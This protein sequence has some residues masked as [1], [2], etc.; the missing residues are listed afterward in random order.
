MSADIYEILALAMRYWFVLL[1]CLIVWRAFSWLRKDRRQTHKR[2]K[3]LPD[4]GMIGELVVLAGSDRLP[5]GSMIPVPYEGTLGA[6]R[7]CD[8][9]V[10]VHSVQAEHLDFSFVPGKGL[11]IFPRKGCACTVDGLAIVTRRDS[12]STPMGH[13]SVL[14]IGD[15][16]V[17]RLRL[18]AGLDAPMHV[19]HQPFNTAVSTS[20]A[21][22][23]PWEHPEEPEEVWSEASDRSS[24]YQTSTR[25]PRTRR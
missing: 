17:L 14:T 1:G 11:L 13:S 2:L 9:V 4:A 12:R 22:N 8:V 6:L 23:W 21:P 15:S 24:Q 16:V 25:R 10:P 5:E 18:L 7:T 19:M 3:T 20:F